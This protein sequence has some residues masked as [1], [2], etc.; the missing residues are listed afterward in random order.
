[1][2]EIEATLLLLQNNADRTRLCDARKRPE[3]YCIADAMR[4]AIAG[5]KEPDPLPLRIQEHPTT[6]T[7]A[8]R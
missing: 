8:K 4:E 7:P 5:F 6:P 1:M 2:N 3:D